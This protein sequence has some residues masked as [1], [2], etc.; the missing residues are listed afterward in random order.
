MKMIVYNP[1]TSGTCILHPEVSSLSIGVGAEFVRVDTENNDVIP[2]LVVKST[3]GRHL[4]VKYTPHPYL[5]GHE[6][7]CIM[8]VD[9]VGTF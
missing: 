3:V 9:A 1:G 6:T 4:R 5:K 7:A 8:G 2:I